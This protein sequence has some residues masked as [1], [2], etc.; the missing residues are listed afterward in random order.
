MS[1]L[2]SLNFS[3]A[4]TGPICLVL[5]LGILLKRWGLL[6]DAFVDGASRLVFQ[7]TLPALLF[8]SVV[9]TDFSAMPSPWLVVYGIAATVISFLLLEWVASHWIGERQQ[10]GIFVQGSFRGNMGIMGLAYVQNAYGTEGIGA[11]ALYVGAVTVL[12]NVLAVITLTR[13]LGGEQGWRPIARGIVRNPLIIAIV[14]GLTFSLLGLKLPQLLLTT[15][16]YFANLTLPLALLCT[17]ASLNLNV[18]RGDPRLTGWAT[19]NRLCLIPVLMVI[20]AMLLGFSP[21][22]LGILFLLSSTPT[23]AASY[24]M[25]R[26]M[27]GDSVLAA[28]II[29][30]TTLGSLVSTSIG[31]A[32]MSYLGLMA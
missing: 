5:I 31:A 30:T 2:A 14:S 32:L 17:G 18:L 28:N 12:Y 25:T 27:G 13:S 3:L 11:A 26:A 15:G 16:H 20:G 4:I 1:L 23:A 24:V 19:A 29:A 21:Q 7:V 6:P 10:R 9:R 22:A 8:L